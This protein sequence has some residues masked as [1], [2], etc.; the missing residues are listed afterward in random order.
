MPDYDADLSCGESESR[1]ADIRAMRE[2]RRSLREGVYDEPEFAHTPDEGDARPRAGLLRVLLTQAAVFALLIGALF[3]AQRF[4]PYSFRHLRTAYTQI[5]QTDL[6]AKEVWAQIK[7]AFSSLKDEVYVVAPAANLD[8]VNTTAPQA[9]APAA[10]G[11][12]GGEDVALAFAGRSCSYMPLITTIPP[13]PPV[14]KG[15]ITSH[16]GLRTHPVSGIRGIHTGVDIGAD[17]GDPIAAA[18]FGR[19]SKTGENEDYGLYILMDHG[20]GMQTFY[21]HCSELLAEEGM[22]LRAGE[23]IA[24]VGSTGVSTGPHLHFEI[25]LHGLRCDPEPLLGGVYPVVDN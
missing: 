8:V 22:V 19:V 5:M 11:A 1:F 9:T 23:T 15:R 7:G 13:A 3:L 25:R 21:G 6:S 20:G 24:L 16:F 14:A 12:G 17:L 2:R 10:G 4:A 18:F